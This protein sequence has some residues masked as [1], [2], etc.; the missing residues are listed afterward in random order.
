MQLH[1]SCTCRWAQLQA[2]L[3]TEFGEA[4]TIMLPNL[5]AGTIYWAVRVGKP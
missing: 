5:T 4:T 2:Y 1:L 3:S